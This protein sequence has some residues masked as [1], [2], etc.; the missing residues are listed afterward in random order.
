MS[1][2]PNIRFTRVRNGYN[3]QEADSV[4]DEMQREID[5][6]KRDKQALNNTIRQYNEKTRQ[7]ADSTKQLEEERSRESLRLTGMI[8]IAARMAEQTENDAKQNAALIVEQARREAAEITYKARIEAEQMT[9]EANAAQASAH[10]IL[11][12]LECDMQVFK[13][14][15]DKCNTDVKTH[16][17]DIELLLNKALDNIPEPT[18]APTSELCTAPAALPEETPEQ[19]QESGLDPY[20]EFIKNMDTPQVSEMRKKDTF[21]GHFGD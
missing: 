1:V 21:L 13:Q 5:E 9:S 2:D 12:N 10:S 7:L 15:I 3:P 18:Q 4:F 17:S 19:P 6:L 11:T 20:V 14:S 16:L 8:N